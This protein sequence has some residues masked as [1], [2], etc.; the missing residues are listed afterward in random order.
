M[1]RFEIGFLSSLC[2][3][4]GLTACATGADDGDGLDGAPSMA[5]D[6]ETGDDA[7][8][9]NL[10]VDDEDDAM[11]EPVGDSTGGPDV[12]PDDGATTG[13]PDPM[14]DDGGT[15]DTGEPDPTDGGTTG[16]MGDTGEPLGPQAPADGDSPTDPAVIAQFRATSPA[17]VSVTGALFN[18][19]AIDTKG[20]EYVDEVSSPDDDSDWVQFSIVPGQVDPTIRITLECDQ[21][22]LSP[23]PLSA[24]LL[25]DSGVALETIGC[26]DGTQMITLHN[27]SS[28][29]VYQVRVQTTPGADHYD[30]YALQID[31]FCF[32]GCDFQPL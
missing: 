12:D 2:L 1:Q 30:A 5:D 13:E 3:A 8:D 23:Q 17:P 4:L 6:G 22:G 21:A 26:G 25:D 16:E 32:Q 20:L 19:D 27:A 11:D 14:D 9:E 10:P 28:L 7:D 15:G 31:A 24:V 18:P 29:D